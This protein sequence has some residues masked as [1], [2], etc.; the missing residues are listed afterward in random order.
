MQPYTRPTHQQVRSWLK[1]AVESKAPPP[2]PE[3]IREQL[4]WGLLKWKG[5]AAA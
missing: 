2:S 3:R 4:G 1:E 5:I